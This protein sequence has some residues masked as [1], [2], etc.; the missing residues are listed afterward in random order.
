MD[1]LDYLKSALRAGSTSYRPFWSLQ[2]GSLVSAIVFTRNIILLVNILRSSFAFSKAFF[3]SFY[4]QT[5]LLPQKSLR[6]SLLH[7]LKGYHWERASPKSTPSS[8]LISHSHIS[9][10]HLHALKPWVR[11]PCS[12]RKTFRASTKFSLV[13]SVPM[14]DS[15]PSSNDHIRGTPQHPLEG[16]LEMLSHNKGLN[17]I[18]FEVSGKTLIDFTGSRIGL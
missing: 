6:A 9:L 10:W 1:Y 5:L 15:I 13:H 17:L 2:I 4:L 7:L 12:K 3:P 11:S 8:P 18:P 14:K 16:I